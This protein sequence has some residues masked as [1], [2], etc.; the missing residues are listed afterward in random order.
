M[1]K[2]SPKVKITVPVVLEMSV[3]EMAYSMSL[4]ISSLRPKW[5]PAFEELLTDLRK[6]EEDLSVSKVILNHLTEKE[7]ISCFQALMTQEFKGEAGLNRLIDLYVYN[8][9]DWE[10]APTMRAAAEELLTKIGPY[11]Q[12]Q[13]DKRIEADKNRELKQE[14]AQITASIRMLKKR[15]YSVSLKEELPRK[16]QKKAPV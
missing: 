9:M 14:K 12:M 7:V 3:R 8:E 2:K 11:L 15:G 6:A 10:P 5:L 16:K 13:L 1:S 4:C